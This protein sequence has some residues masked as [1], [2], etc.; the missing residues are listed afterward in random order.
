MILAEDTASIFHQT[1]KSLLTQGALSEILKIQLI[2]LW[3]RASSAA[4][5]SIHATWAQKT[6]AQKRERGP[7]T[8]QKRLEGRGLT[9][10]IKTSAE[11]EPSYHVDLNMDSLVTAI[12]DL[13]AFVSGMRPQFRAHGGSGAE[14]LALQNIQVSTVISI[15]HNQ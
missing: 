9:Y 7:R 6:P 8:S 15:L 4:R 10:F 3:T 11:I 1:S 12:R 13:F 5:S 14:N 2:L